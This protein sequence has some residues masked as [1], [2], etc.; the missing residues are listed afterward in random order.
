MRAAWARHPGWVGLPF[1]LLL[2]GLA[3]AS[4]WRRPLGI[5]T[6]QYLYVGQTILDGGMPYA[7][8]ANNKG[9]LL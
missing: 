9:P 4:A 3:R 6:G 1:L 2:T 5:D 7:D 8:A